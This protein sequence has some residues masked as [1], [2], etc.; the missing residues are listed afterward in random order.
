M[1]PDN[2][3][4]GEKRKLLTDKTEKSRRKRR[5]KHFWQIFEIFHTEKDK[6]FP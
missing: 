3:G 5:E 6:R 1:R 2:Q 4:G